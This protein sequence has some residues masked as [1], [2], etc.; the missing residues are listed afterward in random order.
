MKQ[1]TKPTIAVAAATVPT[2]PVFCRVQADLD[3]IASVLGPSFEANKIFGINEACEQQ[4]PLDFY[5][6]FTSVELGAEQAFLS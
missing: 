1:Y 4:V 6:K 5:C 2:K 3:I